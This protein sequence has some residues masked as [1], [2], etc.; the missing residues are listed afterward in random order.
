MGWEGGGKY[1]EEEGW[2]SGDVAE[3]EKVCYLALAT[4]C[5]LFYFLSG[6]MKLHPWITQCSLGAISTVAYWVCLTWA[7]YANQLLPIGGVAF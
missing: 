3:Q 5:G 6:R 1:L 2:R 4:G 7:T